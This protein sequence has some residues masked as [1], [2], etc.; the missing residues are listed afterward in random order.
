[1]AP[2]SAGARKGDGDGSGG[3]NDRYVATAAMGEPV[4]NMVGTS[5]AA[6]FV[7]LGFGGDTDDDDGGGENA[8]VGDSD[9][10][11]DV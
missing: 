5:A 8:D 7:R 3:N 1:M 2:P 6:A 11:G 9:L 4:C 10:K